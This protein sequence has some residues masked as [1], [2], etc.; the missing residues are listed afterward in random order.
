MA[1]APDPRDATFWANQAALDFQRQNTLT[2]IGKE[3]AGE[4]A[5][6]KYNRGELERAEPLARK[7]GMGKA[8]TE[9]LLQSGTL[10]QRQGETQTQ[11]VGKGSRLSE[12]RQAALEKYLTGE[13]RANKEY[14]L[15]YNE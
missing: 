4:E 9:G 10:A 3:R 12:A 2:D 15:K 13:T 5:K 14:G 11:Y 1:E 8:N 6:Y 7:R